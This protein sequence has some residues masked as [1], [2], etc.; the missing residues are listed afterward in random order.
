MNFI[1]KI[2]G[3]MIESGHNPGDFTIVF[4]SKRAGVFLRKRLTDEPRVKKPFWA[5]EILTM[6]DLVSRMS[7][8]VLLDGTSLTMMLYGAYADVYGKDALTFDKFYAWA[9]VIIS[10]FNDMDQNL[11]DEKTL[12]RHLS[13][14]VEADPDRDVVTG[15]RSFAGN[16]GRLYEEFN[17][18][19]AAEDAGYYG[20]LVKRACAEKRHYADTN[21]RMIIAGFNALSRG[22]TEIFRYLEESSGAEILW[23]ADRYFIDNKDHE[24]GTFFREYGSIPEGCD[25][26]L[27]KDAKKIKVMGVAGAAGQAKAASHFL[28]ELVESGEKVDEGDTA[29]VLCDEQMLFPVINSIPDGI[30]GLNVT[31]GY[32]LL[33]TP[34]Q[35]LVSAL[36]RLWQGNKSDMVYVRDLE[37]V[38]DHPYMRG[39]YGAMDTAVREKAS[40]EPFLPADRLDFVPETL[41]MALADVKTGRDFTSFILRLFRETGNAMEPEALG[42]E[43][44]KA[45]IDEAELFLAALDSYGID[46]DLQTVRKLFKEILSTK[47]VPFTGE[48]LKGLQV[49]GMLETR[50]LGFRNVILLG[51][52][53][54]VFPKGKGENSIIPYELKKSLGM[55]TYEKKDAIFSY[56]YYRLLKYGKNI[57]ICYNTEKDAFGKGERS[58]FIEQTLREWGPANPSLEI[59]RES[60]AFGTSNRGFSIVEIPKTDSI[61]ERMEGIRWSP[62]V[63]NG[64]LYCPV[65]FY[66]SHLMRL[67]KKER[68]DEVTDAGLFGTVVHEALERLYAPY[69]GNIVDE[70]AVSGLLATAAK[71]VDETYRKNMSAA[72]YDKGRHLVNRRIIAKLIAEFLRIDMEDAP[73]RIISLEK[74]YT[75]Q[76]RAAG[77]DLT[78]YGYIDRVDEKDG[79]TRILDYKTGNIKSLAVN[80]IEP[81]DFMA[82][83]EKK[84]A[85]QLLCYQVMSGEKN[86]R[87]G[88]ISF[89]K[90]NDGIKYLDGDESTLELGTKTL[91]ALFA[92]IFDREMPL[93]QIDD[94]SKCGLCDF[95][96]LCGR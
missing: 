25:D 50:A 93:R 96:D 88:I 36:L 40:E 86:P 48:P 18:R 57:L 63:L 17:K 46:T 19:L 69:A 30:S 20:A 81:G 76:F 62:T 72:D 15:F 80:K 75:T 70:A 56:Y 51:V 5:P 2:A 26:I 24:A 89:R 11:V 95:K 12:F 68:Q 33:H 6:G 43:F 82:F 84:E 8:G 37:R 91:E 21:G 13:E 32:P 14:H 9:R 79:V 47:S 29:V 7:G 90:L 64:Y 4:P 87:L 22:E 67:K 31:M 77:R 94:E 28:K 55:T 35:T 58:R 83:K 53:E 39:C 52:N 23:D 44:L 73:F 59:S 27:A 42:R 1:D 85:L 10:D 92:D 3:K 78:L 65:R 74:K 54:K 38:L 66:F 16:Y 34:V 60:C 45:F 49:M 61:I 41:R 71:T